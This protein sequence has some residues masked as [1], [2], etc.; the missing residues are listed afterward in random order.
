MNEEDLRKFIEFTKTL[1]TQLKGQNEY[2]WFFESFNLVIVNGFFQNGINAVGIDKFQSITESDIVRIKAYLSFVDKKALNFGKEFYK[3]I[4]DTNLKKELVKD[5]KAMKIALKNEDIVEF[6]RR[7]SL[8][9]ENIYNYSLHELKVH[10][11]INSNKEFFSKVPFKWNERAKPFDYNFFKS[12]YYYNQELKTY[13]PVEL[14]KVSFNT[15]SVFLMFHF[16]FSINKFNLDDIYFLRNKGSHRGTL[17]ED[18]KSKLG[19]IINNFDKNY[20]FYYKVLFDVVN[21]IH[22]IR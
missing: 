10:D 15:K 18:E 12:F 7:I 8:Q 19:S 17:T 22:N 2:A 11:L 4:T 1:L 21:G 3:E 5:F 9:I 20:S 14:S 6:G 16:K 13:F